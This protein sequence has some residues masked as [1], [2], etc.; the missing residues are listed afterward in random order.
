MSW[1]LYF[2]KN[3]VKGDLLQ[4]L[5]VKYMKTAILKENFWE[6]ASGYSYQVLPKSASILACQN[7]DLEQYF[8]NK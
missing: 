5:W 4:I 1:Q 6:T 7:G 2:W 3:S 8:Q